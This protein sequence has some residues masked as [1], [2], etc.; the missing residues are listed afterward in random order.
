MS[1]IEKELIKDEK[2]LKL[3]KKHFK[4]ISKIKKE[5]NK[6]FIEKYKKELD[7]IAPKRNWSLWLNSIKKKYKTK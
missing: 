7:Q 4:K 2:L 5:K 1:D 3:I 6:T